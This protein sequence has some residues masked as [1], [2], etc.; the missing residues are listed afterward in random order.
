MSTKTEN[1]DVFGAAILD[2]F[3]FKKADDIVVHSPDFD[4]DVIEVPYLFRSYKEMPKI[5]QKALNNCFG[6]VLDVGCGAGSH[7]LYLQEQKNLKVTAIDTSEAAV[8]TCK[9]RGI[10]DA[11]VQ[12]FFKMKNEQFDTILFM[13]NG[14]GIVGK[15]KNLDEF[16][17]KL[18]NLLAPNGQVILDSSDLRYL[19]DEDEDGGIWVDPNQYYG[20][21][22]FR[23]S[24]KDKKTDTFNWLY[25]DFN[26]LQLAALKNGFEVDLLEE[27]KHYDYLAKLTLSPRI[28]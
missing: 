12:D 27:G 11:R 17:S 13:M 24:Y 21:L 8:E 28:A 1:K 18:K 9:L 26:S 3:K 16:F 19:F 10:K 14:I 25:I 2:F 6:R 4:D 15:L 20:E 22:Q 7:S 23:M 5:E